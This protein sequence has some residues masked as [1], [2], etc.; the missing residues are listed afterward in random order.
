M[1]LTAAE[2]IFTYIEYL[3]SVKETPILK[4]ILS[5]KDHPT[6]TNDVLVMIAQDEHRDIVES[7]TDALS[8]E[9]LLCKL[10]MVN[11]ERKI[12]KILDK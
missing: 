10:M 2:F 11:R 5:S 6:W 4:E 3:Y 9:E 7:G 1:N 8:L 12:D